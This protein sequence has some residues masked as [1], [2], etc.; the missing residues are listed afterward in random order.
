MDKLQIALPIV[1]EGRYDKIKLSSIVDGTIIP[2]DGFALFNDKE[3]QAL[4]RRLAKD[5]II[6]LTDPDGGGKQLRSFLSGLLGTEGVYHLHVPAE[7]GKERRKRTAGKAG[8]LGVEGIEADTLR[9]LLAPFAGDAPPLRASLTKA[10]LYADGLS[11]GE[12]SADRRAAVAE[13]LSLPKNLSPNAFL[14]AV[15][16][17]C[18]EEEY[19]AALCEV[20]V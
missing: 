16:L 11:G 15:N 13:R 10:D 9:A 20:S 8:L 1:V 17:L 2:T 18:T 6:V 4:L 19:R 12:G 14:A 3:K 5:G 7:K